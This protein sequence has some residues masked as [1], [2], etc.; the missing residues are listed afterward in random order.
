MSLKDSDT[1][2]SI[3]GGTSTVMI[4]HKKVSTTIRFYHDRDKAVHK[5]FLNRDKSTLRSYH[6]EDT[7]TLRSFHEENTLTQRPPLSHVTCDKKIIKWSKLW[8][9]WF[10]IC[11]MGH[12]RN[13]NDQYDER[14]VKQ[15]V[16]YG[17][18]CAWCYE[19]H[20]VMCMMEVWYA[21]FAAW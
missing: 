17:M 7:M 16:R 10:I 5:S 21:W 15:D 12:S 8:M 19:N 20:D 1:V 6:D 3:R 11:T 4:F 9:M 14:D 18:P 2:V 13:Q